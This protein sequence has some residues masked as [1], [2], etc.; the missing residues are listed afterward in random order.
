MARTL[1]EKISRQ[2]YNDKHYDQ[3]LLRVQKGK[4]DEYKQSAANFGLG[5]M[6]MMR[7]AIEE[8]IR[9]HAGEKF[10]AATTNESPNE[11]LSDEEKHL[12]ELFA[13]LPK[14][15]RTKFVS[16]LEDFAGNY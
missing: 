10:V 5:F 14:N 6:Q 11:N 1:G 3:I 15:T 12:L 8:F 13:R 16:L 2:K 7:L 4:R 9:T